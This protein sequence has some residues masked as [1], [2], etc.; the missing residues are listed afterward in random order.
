MCKSGDHRDRDRNGD[1]ALW[2]PF[3]SAPVRSS[4]TSPSASRGSRCEPSWMLPGS[5]NQMGEIHLRP[6]ARSVGGSEHAAETRR[7]RRRSGRSR[8]GR[9]RRN[10]RGGRDARLRG[11]HGRARDLGSLLPSKVFL[12]A[13]GPPP[14]ARSWARAPWARTRRTRSSPV[15]AAIAGRLDV[16]RLASV[17]PAHP[18]FGRDHADGR[19]EPRVTSRSCASL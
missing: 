17:W 14:P 4:S 5:D 3:A 16:R 12:G 19:S 15:A 18:T 9:R 13:A 2:E 1:H 7:H 8:R 10:S 11:S 6:E